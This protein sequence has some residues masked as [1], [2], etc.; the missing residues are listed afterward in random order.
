MEREA[1]VAENLTKEEGNISSSAHLKISSAGFS[2]LLEEF[3]RVLERWGTG[4][5]EDYDTST[6]DSQA[7]LNDE[8]YPSVRTF[9]PRA[10]Q[11]PLSRLDTNLPVDNAVSSITEESAPFH[12]KNHR[13]TISSDSSP[14]MSHTGPFLEIDSIG[15]L[16]EPPAALG[17]QSMDTALILHGTC[18]QL[19]PA[20]FERLLP[21]GSHI[22]EW[23]SLGGLL[24]AV[25]GRSPST[26]ARLPYWILL[27][28][29]PDKAYAY[30]QRIVASHAALCGLS[31]SGSSV[32]HHR[33]LTTET[34]VHAAQDFTLLPPTQSLHLRAE[35][36]PF[37]RNVDFALRRHNEYTRPVPSTKSHSSPALSQTTV[38]VY[39]VRIY[40]LTPVQNFSL[41]PEII[42]SSIAADSASRNLPWNIFPGAP[43]VPAAAI[44]HKIRSDIRKQFGSYAL[45]NTDAPYGDLGWTVMFRSEGDARRF[46][47]A[48]HGRALRR[49]EWEEVWPDPPPRVGVEAMW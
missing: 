22:S 40:S 2:S 9:I 8:E 13:S 7:H 14:S 11:S 49:T 42:S 29:T 25:P 18:S 21:S 26:L 27:F 32:L 47:R 1:V 38:P 5:F 45:K 35:I 44:E 37:S 6:I 39:A 15:R 12:H 48:W 20:D 28:S 23:R 43:I 46:V 17:S 19:S 33:P 34:Q 24:K 4:P 10:D 41:T 3:M 16:C 36:P 31:G 30:Q